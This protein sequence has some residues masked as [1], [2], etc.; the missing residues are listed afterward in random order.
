MSQFLQLSRAL[1]FYSTEADFK[2]VFLY[3]LLLRDPLS[4]LLLAEGV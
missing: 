2:H 1:C 3:F 4:R